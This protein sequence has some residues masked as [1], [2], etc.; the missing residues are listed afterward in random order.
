MLDNGRRNRRFRFLLNIFLQVLWKLWREGVERE[1]KNTHCYEGKYVDETSWWVG[2]VS[3]TWEECNVLWAEILQFKI[4][5]FP[6]LAVNVTAAAGEDC[7]M[8]GIQD[9]QVKISFTR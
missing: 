4:R 2:R 1:K 9:G 3:A 6:F 8:Y 7:T 5:L